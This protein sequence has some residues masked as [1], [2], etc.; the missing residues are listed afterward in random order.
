MAIRSDALVNNNK[1]KRPVRIAAIG[2]GNR[3]RKYLQ[4]VGGHPDE[5]VL[6]M[7]VEP[8]QER[9]R[10]IRHQFGLSAGDCFA[11]VEDFFARKRNV[12]AVIIGTP[13]D[14]HFS[15]GMSAIEYGYHCLLEK[16]VAQT[17]EQCIELTDAARR[18]GVIVSV[19]YVLR[20]HPFYMKLKEIVSNG[21]LGPVISVNHIENVGLD[22]MTHSYVRGVWGNSEAS[23]PIFLSKCCHDVDVL[24]WITGKKP[25]RLYSF[26]SLNWF[27]KEN[28]PSGSTERC[29]DCPVEGECP[30]SAV[31][32]YDRRRGW[33]DNFIVRK[34]ETL[35][36]RIA[37][38]L[39]EGRFGRC[40]YHCDNDVV[41]HQ[42]VAVEMEDGTNISIT[43]CAFTHSDKRVTKIE[44]A[45]GEILADE[46]SIT[47][48]HFRR[49][50]RDFLNFSEIFNQ[51]L[52]GNS[53]LK[54][55]ADFIKAVSD[56][57][58]N[59]VRCPIED[60][61]ESHRVCFKA[62]ESRLS[63]RMMELR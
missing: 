55:V 48:D 25:K 37:R 21:E 27:R 62:E 12:D 17:E 54:I 38:E 35:D 7:I 14:T 57:D 30:F 6:S 50:K 19:C 42:T 34:G 8:D 18:K 60:A 9:R 44:C 28:A 29:I 56:P 53:D 1:K 52:H 63:G 15:I 4:Y 40:V 26:G 51:P 39:K 45:Y 32:L 41:D 59:Q 46:Q 5:A 58:N 13:D 20:Y 49:N 43:M 16:P 36:E 23:C 22:R 31:D 61:L 10:E 24:L 2:L 3:T 47:I 11:S 33:I